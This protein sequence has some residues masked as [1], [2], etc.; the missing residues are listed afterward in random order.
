MRCAAVSGHLIPEM[1]G[2]TPEGT[3]AT[4]RTRARFINFTLSGSR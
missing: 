1:L 4:A 2:G 3:P